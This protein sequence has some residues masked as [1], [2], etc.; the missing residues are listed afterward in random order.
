MIEN[1]RI[2]LIGFLACA[3]VGAAMAQGPKG[4]R[5]VPPPAAAPGVA[6]SVSGK[7]AQFNY[8]REGEIE[9]FLLSNSNT[10]VHLPAREAERFTE[11][12]HK[13]D[14]VQ[15]GGLA[16]TAPS[17]FQSMDAQ[18]IHDQTSGKSFTVRDPGAAAPLSA[19]GRIQQLN[20][21]RDG[22]VNGFVLDNGTL[23]TVPP[24]GAANPSSIRV[25]ANVAFSGFA[26]AT[27]SGRNVVDVQTLTVD[28]QGLTLSAAAGGMG[29][30]TAPG[31]PP[32]PAPPPA[33]AGRT[34]EPP[35]PP[36][37]PAAPRV[38]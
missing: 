14:E 12:L 9:G 13:G 31:V 38:P 25:G 11:S 34:D 2:W 5:G 4:K 27:I 3:T 8:D 33:P 1:S 24:F 17:G 21:G 10:L 30:A 36:P 19:S 22:A 28:G 16:A 15:V 29:R 35:P 23:A 7:V 26:H 18:T 37:L 6:T 32:A 20:Y